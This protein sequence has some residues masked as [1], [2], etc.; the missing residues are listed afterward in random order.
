MYMYVAAGLGALS[1]LLFIALVAARRRC[2][3]LEH[4]NEKLRGEIE[5]LRLTAEETQSVPAAAGAE[6]AQAS[7]IAGDEPGT[8]DEPGQPYQ[9]DLEPVWA[10]AR[11]QVETVR[12]I[13]SLT[14][15]VNALL[16]QLHGATLEQ[17]S[18]LEQTGALAEQVAAAT[19]AVAAEGEAA[20][21]EASQRQEGAAHV[22]AALRQAMDGMAAI[23][24]AVAESAE[25]MGRLDAQM[26][27]IGSIV[28]TTVDIAEQ[29]N[30]LALNAAIEAARAGDN[31]KGF[32]VVAAEVRKLADRSRQASQEIAQ[33]LGTIRTEAEAAVAAM[34]SGRAE[35][36]RGGEMMASM[37]GA[38]ATILAHAD[39]LDVQV[40]RF[41][42]AA[43]DTVAQMG[44][45][46][47]WV[48]RAIAVCETNNRTI[49]ELGES[50]WFSEALREAAA[51]CD[52]LQQR[53]AAA[54]GGNAQPAN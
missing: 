24:E 5:A 26:A 14:Q 20:R 22:Q 37:Q 25:R 12:R 11:R 41:G 13:E 29:T 9:P 54:L 31:G 21:R 17:L 52:D 50:T 33:R 45:L 19:K 6:A 40:E 38:I 35:V 15:E 44:T 39:A 18:G 16:G 49:K 32:A 51:A 36:E 8:L 3:Q 23:Q 53:V 2:R 7:A 34:Q 10:A 1:L 27:A 42:T 43:G 46:V 4:A 30:L 28:Q 47:E 48:Q